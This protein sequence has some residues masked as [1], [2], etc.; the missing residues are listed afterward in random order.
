MLYETDWIIPK[1]ITIVESNNK[2][3]TKNSEQVH[4]CKNEDGTIRM[5]TWGY[6]NDTYTY[7]ELNPEDKLVPEAYVVFNESKKSLETAN[8]W[9]EKGWST[10]GL[11]DKTPRTITLDGN[12]TFK[13]KVLNA[14]GESSQGGKLSF[15]M[16]EIMNEDLDIDVAVGINSNILI[17]LL[18]ESTFVNGICQDDVVLVKMASQLGAVAVNSKSHKNAIRC[19]EEKSKKKGK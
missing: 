16:C 6:R 3:F 1:K 7:I 15:W 12:Q 14:A 13:L 17:K 2:L 19:M 8:K 11:I 9:A 18:T 10:K 5:G 4:L